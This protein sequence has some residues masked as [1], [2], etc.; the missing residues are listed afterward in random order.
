MINCVSVEHDMNVND[1][2]PSLREGL[3]QLARKKPTSICSISR[4]FSNFWLASFIRITD[5]VAEASTQCTYA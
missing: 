1:P 5:T 4:D 3:F 2:Q